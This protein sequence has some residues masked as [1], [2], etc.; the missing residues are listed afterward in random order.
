MPMSS[1]RIDDVTTGEGVA[2]LDALSCSFAVEP[3]SFPC[4][5]TSG[6]GC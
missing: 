2:A 6:C 5:G 3:L 4:P 1:T